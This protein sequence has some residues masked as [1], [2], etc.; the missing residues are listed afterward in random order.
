MNP[1]TAPALP[2]A[3]EAAV[4]RVKKAARAAAE[5]AVD[6]LGVSALA[7]ANVFQRDALLG[8]QFELNRKL[9]SFCNS[10]DDTLDR[11]IESELLPRPSSQGA[12][13]ATAWDA[14]S[15][16]DNHELELQVSAER[17]G[18]QIAHDCE[19]EQRE[20]DGFVGSVLHGLAETPR[21]PLRPELIGNAMIRSIE[22]LTDRPEQRKVLVAELGRS[23]AAAL[24][25]TYAAIVAEMRAAGVKPALPSVRS[26]GG[27]FARTGSGCDTSSR[28]VGLDAAGGGSAASSGRTLAGG[29]SAGGGAPGGRGA[30]GGSA[31]TR[32]APA[33]TPIGQVDAGLMALIRRLAFSEAGPGSG[34]SGYGADA[35][36]AASAS[37][38]FADGL[39]RGAPMAPMAPNL[40]RT[41]RDALREAASGSLDHMVIDVIGSLFDQILS[42]PKVPPQ[43]ARQI[44]RLQLPVLRAALGDT[45]FFSSRKHPVRRFVNRIASLGSAFED[46]DCEAGQRLVQRVRELVQQV[47]EGDF[48][49]FELYDS[50][51][52]A[53]EAFVVEQ[54][55]HEVQ[56]SCGAASLLAD[57]ETDLRLQQ[58]YTQQL[59]ALLGPLPVADFVRDFICQV[60]SQA[61]MR[62]ARLDGGDSARVKRLRHAARELI[63]SVQPKGSPEQRKTFL[64][65]LPTLMKEL[66]EGMDLIG[67]PEGAKK[68]F[69][70]LL[71]PAHAESLKGQALRTL[72]YNL[73]ARQ[74]DSALGEAMPAACELP[75][76]SPHAPLLRDP[77][78]EPR[79]SAEEAQRIGLVDEAAVDWDGQVDIDLSAEAAPTE[80]ELH[81]A[82]LPKVDTPAE[83]A[84]GQSLA[85]HVQIGFAYQMHLDGQWHKVR[86]NHV[87]PG[88][89]FFV[90]THG[91]R[92]KKTISMTYRMLARL[93]ESARLR[94]FEN[95]Y[96]IERATA[97]ARRQLAALGGHAA[98]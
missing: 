82:G 43:M 85:D 72:D 80:A 55:R 56:Q 11:R 8:A 24:P 94:A 16:V 48:D 68:T 32:M 13:E 69:F 74:A 2:A 15:L 21:N 46:L 12:L 49:Q 14:L 47:V 17:F 63:M 58:R 34:D 86:L 87:S 35:A 51:L 75:P 28:P 90:F 29:R 67:W 53:L 73:L 26:G 33:G 93:C 79:F 71:L 81:I 38:S 50:K 54:S 96:L 40:I 1:T 9:A 27:G 83:P 66:N 61:L 19:A 89:S 65:Q 41:H 95:A 84:S 59:Q 22:R 60:W 20:L 39:A 97:R 42:D 52:S 3:I 98:A 44:A 45:S 88:R 18:L 25:Q 6:S 57:K 76:P 31:G 62:A 7:S 64:M 77:A 23:L 78:I 36:F 92:H 37:G 30:A 5:R 4:R 91:G 70:G 10:F